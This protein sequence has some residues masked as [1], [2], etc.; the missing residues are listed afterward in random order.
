[1]I[2]KKLII[3]S[4][5]L[6]LIIN[7]GILLI[8]D[9][10]SMKAS[11]T[12]AKE[13]LGLVWHGP[14]NRKVIA[15]TFDDGPNPKFTPQILDILKENEVKATFFVLGKHALKYPG[16]IER[17]IL[18]G[19]EV[20]NHSFNH[21]NLVESTPTEIKKEIN[22]TQDVVFSTIEVMPRVFRPPYGSYNSQVVSLVK[23]EGVKIVIWSTH[24]D[25][26]DWSNPGVDKIVDTILSKTRNG[27]IILLHDHIEY[28]K[29][30]TIGAL[31]IIIPKLKARGYRFVTVSELMEMNNLYRVN[32]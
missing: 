25:A 12:M 9:K 20:G 22:M 28:D 11:E 27:D 21:V 26:R 1:M 8:L 24:Q 15:L 31:K 13:E 23:D 19:H 17:E 30:D 5:V 14:R 29:S 3:S 7:I 18:E 6:L 2:R 32:N 10:N 4:C 16:L